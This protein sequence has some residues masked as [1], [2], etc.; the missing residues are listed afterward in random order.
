MNIYKKIAIALW[1]MSGICL[2]IGLIALIT[3]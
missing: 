1:I 3:V 2:I